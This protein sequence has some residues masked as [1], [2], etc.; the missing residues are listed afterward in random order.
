MSERLGAAMDDFSRLS[1]KEAAELF[2]KARQWIRD[3]FSV[4][5]SNEFFG[6]E[7]SKTSVKRLRG[8]TYDKFKASTKL[9][10]IKAFK[11][12]QRV[13]PYE[14]ISVYLGQTVSAEDV[15]KQYRGNYRYY[16]I[17]APK[18]DDTVYASGS[19]RIYADP[20]GKPS[21]A[22]RSSSHLKNSA[23]D[24]QHM[25]YVFV[26]GERLFLAGAGDGTLTMWICETFRSSPETDVLHGVSVSSRSIPRD[27]FAARFILVHNKNSVWQEQ[28]DPQ[29]DGGH[30]VFKRSF[31]DREKLGADFI[32]T[33]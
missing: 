23:T 33:R 4:A 6:S 3:E 16:R 14:E 1:S 26:H 27:P 7:L 8:K 24:P 5:E 28:L 25:G 31:D 19:I 17:T 2:E 29:S 15:L 9:T 21:F 30:E 12:E 32:K 13:S 10:V 22:H 11:P 20:D 18:G